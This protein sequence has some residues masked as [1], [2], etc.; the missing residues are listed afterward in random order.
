MISRNFCHLV[1][2]RHFLFLLWLYV[3]RSTSLASSTVDSLAVLR[4]TTSGRLKIYFT[5]KNVFWYCLKCLKLLAFTAR[6]LEQFWLMSQTGRISKQMS[7]ATC[8]PSRNPLLFNGKAHFTKNSPL[9]FNYVH[10]KID[11]YYYHTVWNEFLPSPIFREN[12]FESTFVTPFFA[13]IPTISQK[14]DYQ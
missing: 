14:I 4:L 2:F 9:T 3:L 11:L 7:D 13:N 6:C 12:R 10:F 5:K 8:V 1:H